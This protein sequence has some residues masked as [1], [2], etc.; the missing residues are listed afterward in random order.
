MAGARG[1]VPPVARADSRET[2][3]E[4]DGGDGGGGVRVPRRHVRIRGATR[5]EGM[6]G[7]GARRMADAT[8]G[9]A[10]EGG[11]GRR[12]RLHERRQG[13]E[14]RPCASRARAFVRGQPRS[15]GWRGVSRPLSRPFAKTGASKPSHAS[16]APW[17]STSSRARRRRTRGRRAKGGEGRDVER[18]AQ[19]RRDVLFSRVGGEARRRGFGDDGVARGRVDGLARRSSR[20]RR[21]RHRRARDGGAHAAPSHARGARGGARRDGRR[22]GGW[23][24]AGGAS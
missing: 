13:W 20:E 11:R 8:L 5:R 6:R 15:G 7:G 3:R 16:R 2:H 9:F 4:G 14:T 23:R 18:G 1:T 21:V 17:R 12:R 22:G 10:S 24:F 19:T